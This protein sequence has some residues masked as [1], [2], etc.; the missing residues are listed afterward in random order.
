[1]TDEEKKAIENL[2]FCLTTNNE[3]S[4]YDGTTI[5]VKITN[6]QILL[7]LLSKKDKVID[8]LISEIIRLIYYYENYH[9]CE[10]DYDVAEKITKTIGNI[11][12]HFYKKV[13][14]E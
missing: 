14:E 11:K 1:M 12:K 4:I 7:N 2:K 8:S 5:P 6:I 13:E 10:F 9:T 3:F